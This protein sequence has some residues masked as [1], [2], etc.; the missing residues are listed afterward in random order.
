MKY[1]VYLAFI[2]KILP[3][4]SQ[5]TNLRSDTLQLDEV[6]ISAG[7]F[8]QQKRTLPFQIEQI[9]AKQIAF[10]NSQNAADMLMQTGQ[11]FV[12]KSQGGGGSPVLRGFEANRILLVIDGV[13][14][15]N[16]IFR[17]GHL[18]NVLRIDQSMLERTEIL[19]GPSSVVYGSDALGG[20]I[21][22]RTLTP[23][24]NSGLKGNA[25][26]RYSSANREKTGHIN[27]SYG[28]VKWSY[29]GGFTYSDFGDVKQGAQRLSK[30][31]T[32]GQLLSYP[33]RQ[34]G[35]DVA[36]TNPDPN[37]QVGSGYSQR[38][39]YHKFIFQPSEHTRHTLN[40]QYSTTGNVPRYDRLTEVASGLP[41]FAEWYYGPEKR[42]LTS[43]QLDMT[44]RN[45]LYDR[46]QLT[47][48][49][50]D[51]EESR[52]SRRFKNNN[53]KTQLEKVKVYTLNYDALK[54][55]GI[56]EWKYGVEA[57]YNDVRSTAFTTNVSTNAIAGA[58]TRYPNGGSQT[59][60]VA[61]YLT[62]QISVRDKWHLHAGVRYSLMG[63]HSKFG[64]KEFFPFP[65]DDVKQS[66]NALSGNAGLVFTPSPKTKVNVLFSTGFRTPN[67]DDLAKVFESTAG[68]LIVP[69]PGL[70]PEYTYNYEVGLSQWFGQIVRL[71]A[72]AYYT[73]IRDAIV[74]DVFTL[75]GQSQIMYNG[76]LSK[77][78]ANQNKRSAY[79]Q[80]VN[81]NVFVK[82]SQS[83]Q[84][85]ANINRVVG[86]IKNDGGGTTPLDHI[87]PTYGRL[88]A[89]YQNK[90]FQAEVYSLYNGWKYISDYNLGGEDN[91]QYATPDGM[92][93]WM[94]L[95]ARTSIEVAKSLSLQ[96]ACENI[97]DRNYRYFASGISAPGRNF[98]VTLRA[99]L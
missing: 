85:T 83:L 90:R 49:Y 58:D 92:P 68:S 54:R 69:N 15:N 94:T 99:K 89:V 29:L 55:I 32:F 70:T 45:A 9:S 13:R 77:I 76:T 14:M 33:E 87:P 64:S 51:I 81:V 4:F 96:L 18:Q 88:S 98:V 40:V 62:D 50:Q 56:Q 42:F 38:D 11:V 78:T 31:P 20:V 97:L 10:R 28:G 35:Q 67:I 21:H 79:I 74:T 53:R 39:F 84:F 75:N 36:V 46:A 41:R 3:V 61:L 91:Q 34:N 12:Q 63:L 26:V 5:Q 24:L 25:Y 80:G 48:A 93:A 30:Y 66:P 57:T 59:R 71:E 65:F 37:M 22:F 72:S 47:V 23:V 2:I 73:Q 60:S 8:E 7:K 27:L 82:L 17:G 44:K 19:L 6:V 1:I 52:I 86:K 43:Y 95:N 16:A